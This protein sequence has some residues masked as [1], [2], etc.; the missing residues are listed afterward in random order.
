M[1]KTIIGKT[2]SIINQR[3]A[4]WSIRLSAIENGFGEII[5]KLCKIEPD[6]SKQYSHQEEFNDYWEFKMRS[7]HAFQC[8]LMLKALESFL[9]VNWLLW[10]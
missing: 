7:M 3:L 1:K 8:S 5:K 9:P 6:I 4:K 2:K 10:I